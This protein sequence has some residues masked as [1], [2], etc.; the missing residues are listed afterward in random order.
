MVS[1]ED[2]DK[3]FNIVLEA[4]ADKDTTNWDTF[5]AGSKLVAI[6]AEYYVRSLPTMSERDRLWVVMGFV[7]G[8]YWLGTG[9][10]ESAWYYFQ[11]LLAGTKAG[12]TWQIQEREL[13]QVF[14]RRGRAVISAGSNEPEPKPQPV[15][16]PA[17]AHSNRAERRRTAALVGRR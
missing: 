7:V 9:E 8:A 4:K 6:N 16:R 10:R 11:S 2:F 3:F 14:E 17:H 12:A 1:R 15:L 13:L 5:L